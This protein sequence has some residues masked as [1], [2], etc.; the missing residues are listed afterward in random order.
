MFRRFPASCRCGKLSDEF[1][2]LPTEEISMSACLEEQQCEFTIILLPRHQPVRLNMALPLPLMVALQLVRLILIRQLASLREDLDSCLYFFN[3]KA[4]LS[5]LT[6]V[7]LELMRIIN[8]IHQPKICLNMS[9]TLS[10]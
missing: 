3:I 2:M 8:A 7:L 1:Y 6:H 5:T 4:P 10:A 9:S